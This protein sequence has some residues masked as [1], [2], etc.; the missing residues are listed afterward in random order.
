MLS[1][2]SPL[3][4]NSDSWKKVSACVNWLTEARDIG[5][6]SLLERL[7]LGNTW[8]GEVPYVLPLIRMPLFQNLIPSFRQQSADLQKFGQFAKNCVN[9]RVDKGSGDRK[10]MLTY[11]IESHH[12]RPESYTER[13]VMG[14]AY[15]IVFAGSDTTAIV[16]LSVHR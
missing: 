9:A 8:T 13:D 15:S 12:K 11:I 10:D 4:A 7:L 14:D 3:D 6:I 5:W 16:Y 2:N 1:G